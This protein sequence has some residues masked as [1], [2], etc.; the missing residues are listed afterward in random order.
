M[1]CSKAQGQPPSWKTQSQLKPRLSGPPSNPPCTPRLLL[2]WMSPPACHRA[3]RSG[4]PAPAPPQ[5]LRP[6]NAAAC[7]W[8]PPSGRPGRELAGRRRR[9]CSPGAR[10]KSWSASARCCC[11][12]ARLPR[13]RRAPRHVGGKFSLASTLDPS[14]CSAISVPLP[15]P[16]SPTWVPGPPSALR[17]PGVLTGGRRPGQGPAV[18]LQLGR[19]SRLNG[20]RA[21]GAGA[22]PAAWGAELSQRPLGLRGE[23]GRGGWGGE[24]RGRG[25]LVQPP[26]PVPGLGVGVLWP[27]AEQ[28]RGCRGRA[29]AEGPA[30]GRF[31]ERDPRGEE[32]PGGGPQAPGPRGG[33][34]GRWGRERRRG[35][36]WRRRGRP[37]PHHVQAGGRQAARGVGRPQHGAQQAR[38]VGTRRIA[39]GLRLLLPQQHAVLEHPPGLAGWGHGGQRDPSRPQNP[40]DSKVAP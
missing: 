34:R 1:G 14:C 7:G 32:A 23:T 38:G 31:V 40:G 5:R 10:R 18:W 35:R 19:G 8:R 27:A 20:L 24:G 3:S 22:V 36:E 25:A 13:G 39:A 6:R 2:T 28:P 33:C 21:A 12:R 30:E 29:G 16:G 17:G 15:G 26:P 4:P 11:C 37:G 9:P